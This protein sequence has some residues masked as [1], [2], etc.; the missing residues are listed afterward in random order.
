MAVA[1]T[2]LEQASAVADK[3]GTEA[4]ADYRT[5]LDRVDA[6]SVAVPTSLH[7]EVAGAFLERGIAADDREAAGDVAGRGRGAG[8]AGRGAGRRAPGRPHRAVQPGPLG[9]RRHAAASQVHRRRAALDLH[10]PLDRHRRGPR[11]DDPRPRPGAL[12]GP[13]T[14]PVGRGGGGERLRRPRGHRQRPDRVRGRLR[15]QPDGQPGELPSPSARCGSGARRATS[16]ST[17]RPSR[18]PSSAPPSSSAG[19]RST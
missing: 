18:G 9:A 10:L 6:V 15:R 11:P 16:R 2:R 19:A 5:L 14:G 13:G 8:R 7:R 12:A 4:V 1:D 17:S 3:N